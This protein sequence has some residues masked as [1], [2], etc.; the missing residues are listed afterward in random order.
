MQSKVSQLQIDEG[1]IKKEACFNF[2]HY[3]KI[4]RNEWALLEP[5]F[6]Y[7]ERKNPGKDAGTKWLRELLR[8]RNAVS[9]QKHVNL[10]PEDLTQAREFQEFL[11]NKIVEFQD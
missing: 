5:H 3:E 2:V 7:S 11:L 1:G 8:L 9:H 4:I 6:A 10:G